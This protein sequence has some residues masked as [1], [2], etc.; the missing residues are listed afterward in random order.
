MKYVSTRGQAPDLDFADVLV[1]GLATDGGLYMTEAGR[2]VLRVKILSTP[3]MMKPVTKLLRNSR[4]AAAN[5]M[6]H[7]I[8]VLVK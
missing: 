1:T 3:G 7:D 5:L 4:R 2:R 6:F 8:K